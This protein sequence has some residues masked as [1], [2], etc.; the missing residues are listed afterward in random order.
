MPIIEIKPAAGRTTKRNNS[1]A[2]AS[3]PSGAAS[4]TSLSLTLA[5]TAGRRSPP[6]RFA[7]FWIAP[8]IPDCRAISAIERCLAR[9]Y[10]CSISAQSIGFSQAL[11]LGGHTRGTIDFT[12][13]PRK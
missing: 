3:A 6:S 11:R 1:A 4:R 12:A 5:W 13:T 8:V 2:A 7:R 9:W 10:S